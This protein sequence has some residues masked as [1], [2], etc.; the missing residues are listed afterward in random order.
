MRK[1]F[2]IILILLGTSITHGVYSQH[3][4]SLKEASLV[5]LDSVEYL[6]IS[7]KKLTTLPNSMW[8]YR[9]LKGLDL[10]KNKLT[11]I[12]DSITVFQNLEI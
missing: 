11:S 6:K 7:R 8:R 2:G 9:N 10:S 12:S 1:I 4:L 5:P 3:Y